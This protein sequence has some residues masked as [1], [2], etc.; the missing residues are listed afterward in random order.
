MILRL[1]VLLQ[2]LYVSGHT[3]TATLYN[4]GLN[5]DPTASDSIIVELHDQFDPSVV[6]QSIAVLLHIDGS[7]IA[8]FPYAV[9]GG[10]YYI[11][12]HHRNSI[13]TWSKLPVT[14]GLNTIFDFAE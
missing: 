4:L 7:A 2:G 3:M 5:S 1:V 13:A 6:V 14:L 12:I 10:T 9:F 8:H 11:A